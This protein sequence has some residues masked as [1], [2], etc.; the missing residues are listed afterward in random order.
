MMED[1]VCTERLIMLFWGQAFAPPL[2]PSPPVS[3][4]EPALTKSFLR[5]VVKASRSLRSGKGR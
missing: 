3:E 2:P 5:G 1:V 4:H